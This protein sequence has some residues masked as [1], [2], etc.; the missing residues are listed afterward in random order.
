MRMC[1]PS[2][3]ASS[4]SQALALDKDAG[5]TEDDLVLDCIVLLLHPLLDIVVLCA[6]L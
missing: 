3:F 4:L 5:P 2:E 1:K 6:G